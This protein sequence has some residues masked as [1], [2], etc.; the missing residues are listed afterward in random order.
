M[1]YMTSMSLENSVLSLSQRTNLHKSSSI[2]LQLNSL[3][4]VNF[5]EPVSVSGMSAIVMSVKHSLSVLNASGF[6]HLKLYSLHPL[7]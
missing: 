1:L 2:V 6:L 4:L 7:N 3:E 5:P